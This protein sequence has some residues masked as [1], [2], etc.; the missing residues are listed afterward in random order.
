[1]PRN[2]YNLQKSE[3]AKARK[4]ALGSRR[5]SAPDAAIAPDADAASA[6]V[7]ASAPDAAGSSGSMAA[8]G[9]E[10]GDVTQPEVLKAGGRGLGRGAP[11]PRAR[12]ALRARPAATTNN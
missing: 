7:A 6:P 11:R 5:T 4:A 12:A 1:M 10:K 3:V 8:A 2:V 9:I